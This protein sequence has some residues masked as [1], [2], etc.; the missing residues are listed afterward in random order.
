M[1]VGTDAVLLG[2]WVSHP[3][4]SKILD[5]GTGSGLIAL[6][7]AQRFQS[8][9]ILGIDIHEASVEQARI[10]FANSPWTS[11]LSVLHISLQQFADL[12]SDGFDLIISN[13]PFFSNSLL[14]PDPRKALAKH[15][16]TLS[17][18]EMAD[19]VKKLLRPQGFFSLILPAKDHAGFEAEAEQAGLYKVKELIVSPVKGKAPNRLISTWSQQSN[20]TES[21]SMSI[22]SDSQHYSEEYISLT[23]DFYLAL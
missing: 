19:S 8:A 9:D 7:M 22:R 17:F 1:K 21:R 16:R 12:P 10:N 20:R 18:A 4:P 15:N 14:P 5:I 13:P 2:S 3:G 23:E 6:M 11:R